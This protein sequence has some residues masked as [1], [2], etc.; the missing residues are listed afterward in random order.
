[1]A[2][3]LKTRQEI[4]RPINVYL[5][6][7]QRAQLQ[8]KADEARESLSSLVRSIALNKQ[9]K[10]APQPIT[11]LALDELNRIGNNL[12][13]LAKHLNSGRFPALEIE[14]TVKELRRE[15]NR[16]KLAILGVK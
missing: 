10:P 2:R 3:P 6:A 9:I 16:V 1:M 8:A 15:I 11:V 7:L 4:K 14:A 5:N 13:Q 12:N